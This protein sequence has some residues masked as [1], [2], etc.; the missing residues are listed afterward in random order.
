MED[1]EAREA[2]DLLMDI[3]DLPSDEPLPPKREARFAAFEA[4]TNA[5]LMEVN[6]K[7]P[8]NIFDLPKSAKRERAN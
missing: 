7:L 5:R 6:P 3:A 2:V 1:D 4:F 8:G